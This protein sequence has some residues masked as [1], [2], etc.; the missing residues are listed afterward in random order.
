MDV[1]RQNGQFFSSN[2]T[3]YAIHIHLVFSFLMIAWCFGVR[4]GKCHVRRVSSVVAEF[5]VH[6]LDAWM[7]WDSGL[8]ISSCGESATY[9]REKGTVFI[10]SISFL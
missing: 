7:S 9:S 3:E 1:F 2:L 6:T 4:L 5:E 10:L 8:W